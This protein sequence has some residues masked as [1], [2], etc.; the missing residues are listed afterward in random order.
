M[1]F[2]TARRFGT[3]LTAAFIA[4]G[5]WVGSGTTAQAQGSEYVPP[6]VTIPSSNPF[7]NDK[8]AIKEG[9]KIYFKFCISCHGPAADGMSVFGKLGAD[10]RIYALGYAQFIVIATQGRP[11]KGM[12]PWGKYLD[13]VQLA[14]IGAYLETLAMPG[15]NWK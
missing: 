9:A 1:N 6:E 11:D 7:S 12:P 10:L 8:E 2:C 13:G 15:A 3:I 4:T 5:L 14:K